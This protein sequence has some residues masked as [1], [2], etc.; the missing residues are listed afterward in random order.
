MYVI[1][2]NNNKLGVIPWDAEVLARREV[3]G[4]EVELDEINS[5]KR[6]RRLYLFHHHHVR[7]VCLCFHSLCNCY[8]KII[9]ALW[10]KEPE[11]RERERERI[12]DTTRQRF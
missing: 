5:E 3:N 8:T 6:R 9:S 10:C 1:A 4:I 12:V 11:E 7:H 2:N